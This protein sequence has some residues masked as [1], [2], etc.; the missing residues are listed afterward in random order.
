MVREEELIL[1]VGLFL[2]SD[3]GAWVLV[4][5]CGS[6]SGYG[7]CT[8][9]ARELGDLWDVPILF[10]D[11]LS[12]PEVRELM[13]AVGTLKDGYVRKVPLPRAPRIQHTSHVTNVTHDTCYLAQ[14]P[15]IP[16]W[17]DL[18]GSLAGL[19][20]RA[21]LPFSLALM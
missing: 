7:S 21:L 19:G 15:H 6:S 11:S 5:S 12:D 1:D 20:R 13:A 10:M 3:P 16:T 17:S 9:L 8:L 18:T 14:V 4:E 2:A